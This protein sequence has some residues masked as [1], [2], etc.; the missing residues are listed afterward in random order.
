LK[1][2]KKNAFEAQA[3]L[4]ALVEPEMPLEASITSPEPT[5][6]GITK[7]LG[8]MRPSIGLFSDEGGS[9]IGGH[10]MNAENR[11]KTVAGF[12]KFWDGAKVERWRAGD[13]ISSFCGRRVSAHI[14]VQPVIATGLLADPLANGQGILARFLTV[15]PASAAGTR[16]RAGHSPASD[17]ALE[18]YSARLGELLRR[19][20]PL[21]DGTR[22]ELQLR[23]LP[24]SEEARALLQEFAI[25][26]EKAQAPGA[27]FENVRP[28]ASKAAEHAARLAA[29]L[30]LFDDP[31]ASEVSADMLANGIALANFY[32]GEAC[33][34][35][36]EAVISSETAEAERLRK[37][38]VES[39]EGQ[40]ISVTDATQ[41]GK[42][43][44]S[45]KNK[46]LFKILEHAGWLVPIDGGAI[47]LGRHRREAFLIC[48]GQG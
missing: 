24:L 21:K 7:N 36:N 27:P 1:R 31:D 45:P 26:V 13:G 15:A 23:V 34:L 10:G 29:M 42:F 44:E 18:R 32:I 48:R 5:L 12:S 28:F 39:W 40:H 8:R 2:V 22:N 37:W 3:D 47:I 19:D 20:L 16:T 4:Q 41:R 11:A 17:A 38:L 6:E 25:E 9:F 46:K 35:A 30:T 33:R 14:M 43:R